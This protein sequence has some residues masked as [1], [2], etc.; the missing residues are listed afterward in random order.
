MNINWTVR[1]KSKVWWLAIVPAVALLVQAFL[2]IFGI[3]WD[4]TEWVGKIAAI[5]EAAFVVLTL[6][7]IVVDPTVDGVADSARALTYVD[8]APNVIE[9]KLVEEGKFIKTG[10]TD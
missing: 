5:I 3:T 7:G 2:A 8:P 6:L 10:G 4:Y 1:V 9:T